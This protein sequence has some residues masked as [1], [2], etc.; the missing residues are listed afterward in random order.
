MLSRTDFTGTTAVLSLLSGAITT[1]V[2]SVG[3]GLGLPDLV[4][5]RPR[6]AEDL[7]R[8]TGVDLP[9]LLRIVRAWAAFGLLA[10]DDAGE[11]R[12]TPLT[13][14]LR[15]DTPG[16]LHHRSLQLGHPDL[17]RVFE[18]LG[19][20][21]LD[22][23]CA[24]EAAHK[25]TMYE[26]FGD[27]PPLGELFVRDLSANSVGIG[28]ELARAYAFS[29]VS[30]VVDIGGGDGRMLTRLL[31][32]WP[33]LRGAVLERAEVRPAVERLLDAEG[34]ADRCAVVTGDFFAGVPAGHDMYLLKYVLQDWGDAEA[35]ALLR[36][37]RAAMGDG[38][39]LLILEQIVPDRPT[40]TPR[41]QSAVLDDLLVF[42]FTGGGN[43]TMSELAALVHGS[44]LAIRE[45]ATRLP[46]V[47]VVECVPT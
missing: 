7:A 16:S 37:C 29:G 17:F 38:S 3:V 32:A 40:A 43:R 13:P 20:A 30:S 11:L 12:Q 44:G 4:A 18:G 15:R 2:V 27:R 39:R 23:G 47:D 1:Q 31:R 42:S 36:S 19:T 35:T 6:S 14:L 45:P 26:F 34:V 8:D 25:R 22:G 21:L 9:N 33:H 5:E 41:A 10:I 28:D 24:F 46:Q